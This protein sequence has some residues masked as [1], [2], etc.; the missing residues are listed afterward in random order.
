MRDFFLLRKRQG[1]L[2]TVRASECYFVKGY[3][4]LKKGS[5]PIAYV[6]QTYILHRDMNVSEGSNRNI[7]SSLSGQLD[8]RTVFH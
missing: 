8:K 5:K 2:D 3:D 6:K 1:N 4:A 7:K